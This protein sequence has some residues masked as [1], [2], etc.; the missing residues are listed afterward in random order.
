MSTNNLG[1]LRGEEAV[2]GK[3]DKFIFHPGCALRWLMFRF[4]GFGSKLLKRDFLVMNGV[5][6]QQ[7]QIACLGLLSLRD[8]L[9][10][11]MM[12]FA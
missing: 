7:I 1:F 6:Q 3:A 10:S 5:I 9:P 12:F 2:K 4:S 8:V 11:H